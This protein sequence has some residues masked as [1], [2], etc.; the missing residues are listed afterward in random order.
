MTINTDHIDEEIKIANDLWSWRTREEVL[1]R[2]IKFSPPTA[3]MLKNI[4][5]NKYCFM[6]YISTTRRAL[7]V[8]DMPKGMPETITIDW[9]VLARPFSLMIATAA[10]TAS[11]YRASS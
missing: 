10:L 8:P 6:R 4:P 2:S 7:V 11:S 3:I 5:K 1:T 9:P